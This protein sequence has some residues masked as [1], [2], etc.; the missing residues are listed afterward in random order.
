MNPFAIRVTT[1]VLRNVLARPCAS[2]IPRSGTKGEAVNCFVTAIDKGEEPYLIVQS[3]EEGRLGCIQWDGS[4]YSTARNFALTDFKPRDFR[5]T[6]YYGLS[7][8]CYTGIIDF[9]V[10]RATRW[11]YIKIHAVRTLSRFDQYLFNKKKLISKER[12]GL[13]KMLVNEALDGRA[14]HETL[15]LMTALY[16]IKWFSHP[17]GKEAQERLEFYLESLVETGELRKEDHK[18]VVTGLAL[19]AIEEY[20]EQERKHT[21]NVKI[22]RRALWVAIAVAVLTV[23]QTGLVKL[24]PFLD[25]SSKTSGASQAA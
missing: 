10:N 8:V 20:E 1:A 22:Q 15:D 6:H 25:F 14:E 7:E 4:K 21:E 23:V 3:L 13:L 17:Q 12:K 24:P 9:V 18:Y 11:P 5:I 16:S 2:R 19:R